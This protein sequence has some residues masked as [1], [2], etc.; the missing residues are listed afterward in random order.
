MAR[1]DLSLEGPDSKTISANPQGEDFSQPPAAS[2]PTCHPIVSD[3]LVRNE[4]IDIQTI[5]SKNN[6]KM[7]DKHLNMSSYEGFGASCFSNFCAK[8]GNTVEKTV[9]IMALLVLSFIILTTNDDPPMR[10]DDGIG[11]TLLGIGIPFVP[12]GVFVGHNGSSLFGSTNL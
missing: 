3:V 1:E 7:H 5:H 9:L 6:L 2:E 10:L 4:N 8:Q 12:P 11:I